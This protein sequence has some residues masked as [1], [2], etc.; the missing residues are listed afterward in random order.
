MSDG[1]PVAPAPHLDRRR[2]FAHYFIDRP[3]MAGVLSLLIL[4]LGSLALLRLPISEYPEVVPPSISITASYP[5]ASPETIAETVAGPLEQQ[6][7]GLDGMLY[8]SSQS[9]PD[10][11]MGLGLTFRLG[12]DLNK[13]LVEVQ[14]R[15]QQASPRLPEDVRRLGV[16]AAKRSP[17]LLL[18]VHLKAAPGDTTQDSFT[19]ANYGRLAVRDQLVRIPGI[20]DARVFG[21][22]EYALRVWLD[23]D[24]MAARGLAP[25]DVVAAIREQNT[26]I[27][28][29]TIAQQPVDRQTGFEFT[30]TTQGRLVTVEEFAAIIVRRGSEG[31]LLRLGDLARIELGANS[32]GL[33]SYLNNGPAAGIGIFQAPGSNALA[34]ADEVRATMQRLARSFPP[35]IQYEIVYDPTEFISASIHEVVVTLFEAL[36]L[37]VLVVI[38]FLQT[39]RASMIP[40]LAVPVSIVGT[41]AIM[42]G[43]GFTINALS[44][45]G[46]VLAIGIVV[47]DA[48]VVV[49]NVE[50]NI[51]LGLTPREAT[52]QAM[53]EV[54]GPIIA[55]AL[56]LCAVFIP[57]AFISGLT[58]QFFQ[59]FA[60][61]IAISTVISAFNSLTLSPA[62]A[63]LLLKP[64]RPGTRPIP[65]ISWFFG[66]F[67]RTFAWGG[68]FYVGLTHRAIR[69][70]VIA[71]ILY[72]GL[73]A[74]TWTL[75]DRTPS[76]FIPAQDK[77][78]LFAFAKLPD[79][80]SLDRTEAVIRT[81]TDIALKD[82]AVDA[83]V[84]FPGLSPSFAP[85]SNTGLVFFRLKPYKERKDFMHQA[86]MT[87]G[88]LNGEFFAINDAF[89]LALPPPPI[90]GLG[91]S[92]NLSLYLEDRGNVG[93]EAVFAAAKETL[94]A[95][96]ADPE[97]RFGFSYTLSTFGVPRLAVDI[98]R[99]R[100]LSQG[101]R[102]ADVYDVMQGYFG[103]IYVNDFNRFGRTY[104]VSVSADAPHRLT[105]E[106][107][108]RVQVKTSEGAM[109]PLSNLITV[110]EIAGP[111]KAIHYNT[112]PAIDL[113]V[114][115]SPFA[116]SDS[117]KKAMEEI[118]SRLPPGIH[119]E[120]TDLTYQQQIAG[121]TTKYVFA[122][123]V[124]LVLLV[125]AAFYESV[126]LP[127]AIVLIVPMCLLS[128]LLGVL[129]T[130]GD[131]NIMT[132]IGLIVLI[133]LACK[134]AILIVEF[135]REA[136]MLRGLDPV[137]AALDACRLRLR[138]I[139]MT[140]LA[141]IMGVWPLVAATGAGAELR[142]ATG[143][144][145]FAGMIGVTLFGLLLTPVFYV[146]LRKVFGGK[147][148]HADAEE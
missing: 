67:N 57:T 32:Y 103:S 30:I 95:M 126:V 11:T 2:T 84:Q 47:D 27:A 69:L 136:E 132:Q 119:Y 16:T 9:T 70:S 41:F 78:Y 139:L 128:A 98:D 40:L 24:R 5:G 148:H 82:P 113:S 23:P 146:V 118:L 18:V 37:V 68:D 49:E 104:Q 48:I 1:L 13:M 33:R 144:A 14:N 59:Q 140:S 44:L 6:M 63:A 73:L 64:H 122:L 90:L 130:H 7:T 93:I 145:V 110:R 117:A 3:I 80:A 143:V 138:P 28:A 75:F 53:R 58:G 85:A 45:F 127:L 34:V 25:A 96:Q 115:V 39:W 124:L 131:L 142:H 147:L 108:G 4:L 86:Q 111:D 50:R 99:E 42:L 17:N 38:L 92:T 88:R 94:G 87:A 134:N 35:G 19:L 66:V 61:T 62:L 123:C 101:V 133:G 100:I 120:W 114:G 77:G 109:I 105:A 65:V 83:A 79:G 20:A 72:G 141:F 43:L 129:I 102:L 137:A 71:L 26:Q 81:M 89:V 52:R 31:Q 107:L 76:S 22:G 135:A 8:M 29:G 74:M 56:V 51:A 112:Y 54:S 125:L 10:G 97:H 91:N 12:T 46:L 116:T 106:A 60:L 36:I 15:I 55:T 121:D 21:A